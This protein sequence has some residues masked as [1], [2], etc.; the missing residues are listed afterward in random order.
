MPGIEFEKIWDAEVLARRRLRALRLAAPAPRGLHRP[1]L[2]VLP[3]LRRRALAGG[4]GGAEHARWRARS[5]SPTCRRRS[6]RWREGD[7][8]RT[9]HRGG[10][11]FAMCAATETLDLALASARGGHRRGLCRRDADGPERHAQ[12]G[13]EPEP[14]VPGRHARAEPDHLA[15]LRHRRPP[16]ELA[17]AAGSRWAR[18]PCS[19]SAPRSIRWPTMLVQNH[20]QVI[21]DFYG[22][23]T[24]FTRNTLKPGVTVL[25]DEPGAPWVKYI[26][27]EH[28]QG[29]WTFY[30]R[31]RPG[32]SPAPD[33]R[34]ADGPLAPSAF[35]RL[36]AD[37]QQR[38]VPGG[39]EERD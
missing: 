14:G 5:A 21:P 36:P 19:T 9:S 13:L 11:L 38:A 6:A 10:F 33:R 34:R 1:V 32:G 22:L 29:T 31:P 24:S 12:D 37:P 27:G 30:R 8:G 35:A 15:V 39:E 28:G 4:D 20:R 17:R 2:Q 7:R 26:H 25:A 23:T 3:H 18:S 16:G